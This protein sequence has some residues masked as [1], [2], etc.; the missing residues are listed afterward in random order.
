MINVIIQAFNNNN[1]N[2]KKSLQYKN[3]FKASL[4]NET[5]ED[6]IQKMKKKKEKKKKFKLESLLDI[7]T[8]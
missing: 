8:T 2:I 4:N 3:I 7:E 6:R 1:R 5:C